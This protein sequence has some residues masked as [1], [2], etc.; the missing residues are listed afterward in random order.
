MQFWKGTICQPSIFGR[1]NLKHGEHEWPLLGNIRNPSSVLMIRDA[2]YPK[3]IQPLRSGLVKA[4]LRQNGH[5]DLNDD[6]VVRAVCQR[7]HSEWYWNL[8]QF[9][10]RPQGFC[11][12]FIN[13]T[14]CCK[15]KGCC[16]GYWC[17]S[18]SI[19]RQDIHHACCTSGERHRFWI[20]SGNTCHYYHPTQRSNNHLG[21]YRPTPG[22]NINSCLIIHQLFWIGW[23]P[24]I[25]SPPFSE[26]AIYS[27]NALDGS[28]NLP[29]Q[30]N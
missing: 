7:N 13:P 27:W 15:W 8:C 1:V 16:S 24:V 3:S 18:M 28:E 10:W 30:L 14:S 6:P 11:T 21:K 20:N 2:Q 25:S 29:N 17:Y 5:Q 9:L 12:G 19:A 23:I 26:G 22:A 4:I